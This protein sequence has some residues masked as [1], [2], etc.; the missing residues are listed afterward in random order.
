MTKNKT[1]SRTLLAVLISAATFGA[2]AADDAG[3][4]V[5]PAGRPAF[6]LKP[7]TTETPPS[8]IRRLPVH[9]TSGS[10]PFM[11]TRGSRTGHRGA[12][13]GSEFRLHHR[14]PALPFHRHFSAYAK[15]AHQRWISTT[16]PRLTHHRRQR[17][18]PHLRRRSLQLPLPRHGRAAWRVQSLRDRGPGRR[19]RAGAGAVRFLIVRCGS[20]GR[21]FTPA[22]FCRCACVGW[23]GFTSPAASLTS[24]AAP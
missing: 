16:H 5:A 7:I 20:Q 2:Q 19:P 3:F 6:V 9:A 12:V 24:R 17:Q 23:V 21:R 22:A 4:Y 13:A 1:L 11:S 18:R 10:R 14:V 8:P 15:A